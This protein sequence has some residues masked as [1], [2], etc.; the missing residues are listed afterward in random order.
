MLRYITSLLLFMVPLSIPA[1]GVVKKNKSGYSTIWPTTL[2]IGL[3]MA[4]TSY[5][6][7]QKT[8]SSY[9]I[10][11]STDFNHILVHA[12][13]GSG[14]I[15]RYRTKQKGSCAD[16]HGNYF[17]LGLDYNFLSPTVYHNQFFIGLLYA[18]SFFNF[19]LNSDKLVCHHEP[20][21]SCILA[22][23]APISLRSL[24]EN[25]VSHWWE[26]VVGGKVCVL[27]IL[28]IGCTARYKFAK[29]IENKLF[30]LPFDIP[31]W[32][33]REEENAFGYSLYIL[34]RI[35]LCK[36]DYCS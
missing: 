17:R 12:D 4:K 22:C 30:V 21:K 32:G 18:R 36:I 14:E 31:G 25:G 24:G 29:N 19:Q 15:K 35:P 10:H 9:E 20:D 8:G 26:I 34:T 23:V 5:G 28:S 6:W 16:T 7:F 11:G 3:D 33:L 27:S 13:Y 1:H 2:Y